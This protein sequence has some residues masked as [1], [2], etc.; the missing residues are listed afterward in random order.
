MIS[1][2]QLQA[3]NVSPY[4]KIACT[5]SCLYFGRSHTFLLWYLSPIPHLIPIPT[6]PIGMCHLA[7]VLY[8]VFC[9]YSRV[10][11]PKKICSY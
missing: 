1:N 4:A 6:L 11:V 2:F 10:L 8:F 5:M 7:N 9:P 3:R